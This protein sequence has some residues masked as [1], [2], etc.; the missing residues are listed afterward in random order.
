MATM[1]QAI[2]EAFEDGDGALSREAIRRFVESR[3]PGE[4]QP[5]T[6]SAHLYARAINPTRP[7]PGRAPHRFRIWRFGAIAFSPASKTE[8][9]SG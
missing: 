6:L 2:R 7:P 9:C 8:A 1:A 5:T 4:W 3:Y